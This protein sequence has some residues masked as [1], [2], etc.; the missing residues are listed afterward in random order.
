MHVKALW[1][2]FYINSC[3]L[4]SPFLDVLEMM[5]EGA[6]DNGNDRDDDDDS[7]HHSN[8]GNSGDEVECSDNSEDYTNLMSDVDFPVDDEDEQDANGENDSS[9]RKDESEELFTGSEEDWGHDMIVDKMYTLA[10]YLF[11]YC[12]Y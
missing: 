7:D 11:L 12:S 6:D 1:N 4:A 8:D 3:S 5:L 10:H 9:S 2:H